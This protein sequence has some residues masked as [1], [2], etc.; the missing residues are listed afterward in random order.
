MYIEKIDWIERI[1]LCPDI[2]DLKLIVKP[3]LDYIDN[4]NNN[5]NLTYI[6]Q[7]NKQTQSE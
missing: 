5:K 6:E 4:Y 3:H 2:D 7:Y 1:L